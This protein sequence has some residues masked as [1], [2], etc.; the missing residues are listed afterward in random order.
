MEQLL[1]A[2]DFFQQKK[3]IHRDIK[4]DNIL[5]N[6][7]SDKDGSYD[8]R[9]ADFGLALFTPDTAVLT[10]NCGTP[11]YVAPEMLRG[12][13]NGYSYKADIFSLGSLFFNLL[14]GRYLFSGESNQQIL[15]KNEK[16]QISHIEAYLSGISN[17]GKA[18]LLWMLQVDPLKRPY[19]KEALNH[20]WFQHDKE[21][22]SDLL[23]VNEKMA[24]NHHPVFTDRRPPSDHQ[25]G[26]QSLK[27]FS[28]FK[29]GSNYFIPKV[30]GME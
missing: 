2:L 13:P 20:E 6:S 18:L 26:D 9:V 14:S 8:I 25:G 17:S 30:L 24:N 12:N 16:C 3:V 29:V 19:A 28:S 11:G 27:S 1:L 23:M 4:L 5:V 10:H 21:V 15:A 7:I 22:L